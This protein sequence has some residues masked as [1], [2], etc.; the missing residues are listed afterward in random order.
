[1]LLSVMGSEEKLAEAARAGADTVVLEQMLQTIDTWPALSDGSSSSSAG[2][3]PA[4][5]SEQAPAVQPHPIPDRIA[6][7]LPFVAA[8]HLLST[9]LYNYRRVAHR[10]TLIA[11]FAMSSCSHNLLQKLPKPDEEDPHRSHYHMLLSQYTGDNF[12]GWLKQCRDPFDIDVSSAMG[13]RRSIADITADATLLQLGQGLQRCRS[14]AEEWFDSTQ[15][16]AC[17]TLVMF[18]VRCLAQQSTQSEWDAS[19]RCVSLQLCMNSVCLLS[20][21]H[22]TLLQ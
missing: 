12:F 17:K 18:L 9:M 3:Q 14:L 19:V 11:C 6:A 2:A 8:A 15:M 10:G 7:S 4:K 21:M 22:D 5:S 1:M 16:D 20:H 13:Y